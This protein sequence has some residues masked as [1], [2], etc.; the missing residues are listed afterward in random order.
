MQKLLLW[1]NADEIRLSFNDRQLIKSFSEPARTE[2]VTEKSPDYSTGK[3]L[4]AFWLE[5]VKASCGAAICWN[6]DC[7]RTKSKTMLRA[8]ETEKLTAKKSARRICWSFREKNGTAWREVLK[9]SGVWLIEL[10]WKVCWRRVGE[11]FDGFLRAW[12]FYL[13]RISWV[14]GKLDWFTCLIWMFGW[15]NWTCL[16]C[17]L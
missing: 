17:W 14:V 12:N 15:F 9:R 7:S 4:L 5:F 16:I 11:N 8:M 13:P 2:K 1:L 10:M 3:K 6:W